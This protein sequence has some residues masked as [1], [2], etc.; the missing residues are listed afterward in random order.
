VQIAVA[1][2]ARADRGRGFSSRVQIARWVAE[3]AD[4]T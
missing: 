4:E 1:V 3:H 2:L